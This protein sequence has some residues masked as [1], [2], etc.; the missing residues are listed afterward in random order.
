MKMYAHSTGNNTSLI[1]SVSELVVLF[2]SQSGY[3]YGIQVGIYE[4]IMG[5]QE[6]SKLYG[7]V[8]KREM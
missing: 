5:I 1:L 6:S 4:L 3:M 7:S 8:F 2:N